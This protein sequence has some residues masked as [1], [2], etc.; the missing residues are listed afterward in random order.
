V[1]S[2]A[3]AA[4]AP[5]LRR[6]LRAARLLLNSPLNDLHVVLV[7]DKSISQLH[8]QFMGQRTPTDVLTFPLDLD[9]RGRPLSGEVYVN[10]NH[11]RREA[12]IR[13]IPLKH[14]LLLYA[15]HGM[16]HL[17]GYDDRTDPDFRR[18]HAKEDQILQ[19][20]G[21]GP[22]FAPDVQNSRARPRARLALAASRPSD[23]KGR[24]RKGWAK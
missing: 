3:G 20:L 14:E 12:K 8:H 16:L 9:A 22:I 15:L 1:T 7:N 2:P 17:S 6:H 13:D 21:I 10:V 23:P 24:T 19:Q 11:A 4:H 5:F 18:M